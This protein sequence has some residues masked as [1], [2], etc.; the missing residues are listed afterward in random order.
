MVAGLAQVD[1]VTPAMLSMIA[2]AGQEKALADGFAKAAVKYGAWGLL[3]AW[4]PD[5]K[6]ARAQ[7]EFIGLVKKF[8]LPGYWRQP[9]HRPDICQGG[10]D[11]PVCKLI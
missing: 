6:A 8:N 1:S 10:N 9:G 7:P 2:A 11:E 5:L 3:L 4:S